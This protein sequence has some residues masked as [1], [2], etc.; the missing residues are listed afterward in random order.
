M[1]FLLVLVGYPNAL[2]AGFGKVLYLIRLF[3]AWSFFNAIGFWLLRFIA[4]LT[5]KHNHGYLA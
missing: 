3:F 4:H 1:P 5:F 2:S